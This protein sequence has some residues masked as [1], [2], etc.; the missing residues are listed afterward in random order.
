MPKEKNKLVDQTS[1]YLLQHANNP[2]QWYPW[3]D[4]ALQRAK[5]E[6]KP[7]L[8]SIGYSACHWCHVMAHESFEDEATA[9]LMNDLY[10]NIKVDREERPDIDKIYQTAQYLLTQRSGGWPLTMFLTPEDQMPFFGGTYFPDAPRHGLP[11]FKELL[12]HISDFYQ[13][14]RGEIS[15]Q[16][17][18]MHQ[19]LQNIYQPAFTAMDLPAEILDICTEH[20]EQTFDAEYGGFGNAPKFPHPSNIERLLRYYAQ[21][22]INNENKPRALHAAIF[23]LEKMA[24]GGIFDHLGGGFCRYSV[25]QY[26][27]IPHFEKMLYDNGPLLALYAHAF[28]INYSEQF[29]FTCEATAEW[30][31]R[32]MQSSEGGYYSTLD[33]DSEGTEGRFYVWAKSEVEEILTSEEYAVF[34]PHFGFD[35]AANFEGQYHLHVFKS[36]QEISLK[37][38]IDTNLFNELIDSAKTK[39]FALRE[40]RVRP[41][42]D[43]K[44]LTSWNALMIRGM[45]IASRAMKNEMYL[46]SA[47]SALEFVRCTMWKNQRLFAT[48][49]AS[50]KESK[51]HLDAYLDDYAFLLDAILEIL[52]TRWNSDELTWAQEI[53]DVILEQF[54]DK[55]VGGFYFTAKDHEQLIQRPKALGDD[56]TPSGNGIAAFALARLGYLL[57]EPKYI[58]AS[59]RALK[60]A[61]HSISQ[62]PIGHTTLLHAYEEQQHPPQII[63]LRGRQEKLSAWQEACH[64]GYAPQR[65]VYAIDAEANNLPGAIAEKKFKESSIEEVTA[66]VCSGT[67]CDAP[68]ESFA[69]LQK[70][71]ERTS[72]QATSH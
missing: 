19:A 12:H 10:I 50:E 16:N 18:S 3:C 27:M 35:G 51:A 57:A 54:E 6:N 22:K 55:E 40:K 41:G 52:Q 43:E 59:E 58:Q 24:A 63:I 9:K 68:I 26:W 65:M 67:H 25:D 66:Y 29:K 70:V 7:I 37:Q 17:Q 8:L 33:A 28:S 46:A 32:E 14:R 34:A 56:S 47:E 5:N 36:E 69:E 15:T 30:L 11:S 21:S 42:R 72:I 53:A 44:I 61:A 45:A 23:T 4:E 64:H 49:K 31:I 2:V 71:L 13:N 62:S 20:L 38:S 48:Y 60:Y 1:P 39:L